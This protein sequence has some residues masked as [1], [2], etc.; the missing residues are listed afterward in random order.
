MNAHKW[1]NNNKLLSKWQQG[2]TGFP[3]IDACMTEINTTGY[4]H[5][6]D[7]LSK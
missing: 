7:V 2:K 5:I 4:M 1:I 3:I 6:P